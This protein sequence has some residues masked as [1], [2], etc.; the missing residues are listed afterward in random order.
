MAKGLRSKIK[1][2]WRTKWRKEV[3]KPIADARDEVACKIMKRSL[4]LQKGGGE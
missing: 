4:D 2:F 3:G 1:R